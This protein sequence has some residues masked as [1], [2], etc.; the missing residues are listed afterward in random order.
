MIDFARFK[1]PST[2]AGIAV[3]AQVAAQTAGV[4][5]DVATAVTSIGTAV[6]AVLAVVKPEAPAATS[7]APK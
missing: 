4:H 6:A 5:G 2:W 3:L 7:D 1:E